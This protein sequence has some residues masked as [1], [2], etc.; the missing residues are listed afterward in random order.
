MMF[1]VSNMFATIN[2]FLKPFLKW[3]QHL[4]RGIHVSPLEKVSDHF[5]KGS[6]SLKKMSIFTVWLPRGEFKVQP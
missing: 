3:L 1:I 2:F 4:Y 6:E 5:L